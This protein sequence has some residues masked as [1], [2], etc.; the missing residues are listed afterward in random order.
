VIFCLPGKVLSALNSRL[1]KSAPT[2]W[3]FHFYEPTQMS[4]WHWSK[5]YFPG[6]NIPKP[7]FLL[8][9]MPYLTSGERLASQLQRG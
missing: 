6:G 1:E 4:A 9:F 5:N 2:F 3:W 7:A 8:A